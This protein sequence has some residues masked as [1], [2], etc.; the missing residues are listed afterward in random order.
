MLGRLPAQGERG[1]PRRLA[2]MTGQPFLEAG[3]VEVV[4]KVRVAGLCHEGPAGQSYG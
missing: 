1:R 2:P 4:E 3:G